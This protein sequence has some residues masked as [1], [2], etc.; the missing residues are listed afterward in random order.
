MRSGAFILWR[1]QDWKYLLPLLLL[2]FML[3]ASVTL[4]YV[5][6]RVGRVDGGSMEPTFLNGDRILITRGYDHPER[7]DIVSFDEV[8]E[9]GQHADVIKRVIALPGDSIRIVGDRAYVNG[10]ASD[11]APD[12][13]ISADDRRLGPFVIPEGSVYVLGDNRPFS[14]DSRY[15]GAVPV[16]TIN[17]EAYAIIWPL[18]RAGKID[19]G[20]V[21]P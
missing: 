17:G 8:V 6:F 11:V 9:N 10:V 13:I 15:T 12:A 20:D 14:L 19:G 5:V 4:L 16:D 2:V 1:R 18:S 3:A 7:G 21:A